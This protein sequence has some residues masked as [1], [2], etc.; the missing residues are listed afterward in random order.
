MSKARIIIL[1]ILPVFLAILLEIAFQFSLPVSY[2]YELSGDVLSFPGNEI[3][4]GGYDIVDN[5]FTPNNEFPHL[6]IPGTPGQDINAVSIEFAQPLD[7]D[8]EV[9]V[10]LPDENNA[11]NDVFTASKTLIKGTES[12]TIAI[13]KSSYSVL[14]VYIPGEFSLESVQVSSNIRQSIPS[15]HFGPETT[16]WPRFCTFLCILALC[17]FIFHYF[18]IADKAFLYIKQRLPAF[19]K[20]LP[21]ALIITVVYG[22]VVFLAWLTES[23]L[24]RDSNGS[25]PFNIF[26]FLFYLAIGIIVCSGIL[27]RKRLADKTENLFLLVALTIGIL[28]ACSMPVNSCVSWDDETHYPRALSTSY[29]FETVKNTSADIL[30]IDKRLPVTFSIKEAADEQDLL[31]LKY[32][33][34]VVSEAQERTSIK[35]TLLNLFTRMAY[36]PSAT[37]LFLGRL[38][39]LPFN[40]IFVLGRIGNLFAFALITFFAIKRL[41][42]GKLILSVIALFVTNIFLAANYSYDAWVTAWVMLGMAYFFGALQRPEEI[43]SKKEAVIMIAS[44][45]IGMS[46]KAIYFPMFFLL[47]FI[48]DSKFSSRKFKKWFRV[49][50]IWGALLIIASFAL[51]LILKGPGMGDVRGGAEVNSGAQIGF[52]LSQ[53]LEY[54][55]IL[56]NFLSSYLS[57][58]SAIGYTNFIAYL[59]YA[60]NFLLQLALL[61]AVTFTDHQEFDKPLLSSKMKLIFS[62]TLFL[63]VLLVA[64]SMYISFTAVSL[65]TIA[66]CQPRYLIPCLFPFL[67]VL[68]SSNISNKMNRTVYQYIVFSV[69]SYILLQGLWTCCTGLY[70]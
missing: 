65:D 33:E 57:V 27:F 59:G 8:M 43:L 45:I 16:N 36:I 20:I 4:F 28:F 15:Y 24:V 62:G 6:F 34:G 58:D 40:S 38:L 60:P 32:K 11:I 56:L 64:T 21:K 31:A 1:L 12:A 23:I 18:H 49:G 26:H 39:H 51:P 61:T 3:E 70:A 30:V 19:K 66:G 55:K 44:F 10:F 46:A 48:P 69:I 47:F 17:T 5:H 54:A 14:Q 52:I 42:S 2:T 50:A 35:S 13:P 68:G 37:G 29:L 41:K 63:T 9:K 25:I 22:G 7:A 67:F 53:P